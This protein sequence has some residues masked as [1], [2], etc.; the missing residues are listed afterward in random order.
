MTAA[1]V[2][3]LYAVLGI[4]AAASSDE[5]HHAFRGLVRHHHP[6]TRHDSMP[7]ADADLRLQQILTAYATLRDPVRRAA[8]DSLSRRPPTGGSAPPPRTATT[9]DSPIRVGPVHWIPER[10]ARPDRPA[11]NVVRRGL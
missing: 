3:D 4:T 8:Y 11:E 6:D 1:P 10:L 5:L 9:S 2:P 7:G